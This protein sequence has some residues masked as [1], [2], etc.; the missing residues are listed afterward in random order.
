MRAATWTLTGSTTCSPTG[1]WKTAHQEGESLLPALAFRCLHS[2]LYWQHSLSIMEPVN[3]A[4]DLRYSAIPPPSLKS[5]C[6]FQR[7]SC[8]WP[9]KESNH[10]DFKQAGAPFTNVFLKVLIKRVSSGPSQDVVWESAPQHSYL[11]KP[12]P[13]TISCCGSSGTPSSLNIGHL[14]VHVS[15]NQASKPL[16]T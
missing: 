7:H 10:R 14:Q 4:L 11:P 3:A 13:S 1:H 5:G 2:A 12:N 16:E 9:T 15:V 8:A 6:P